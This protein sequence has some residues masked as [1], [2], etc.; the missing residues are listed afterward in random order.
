MFKDLY[1]CPYCGYSGPVDEFYEEGDFLAPKCPDCSE[2][3]EGDLV[4]N[5]E[6]EEE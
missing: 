6:E 2:D 4:M 1:T 5:E 3:L